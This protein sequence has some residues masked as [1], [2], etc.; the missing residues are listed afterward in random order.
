MFT[1]QQEKQEG[2]DEGVAEVE[3][4]AD[5]SFNFQLGEIVVDAVAEEVHRGRGAR[6]ERPPPPIV[7]LQRR[8]FINSIYTATSL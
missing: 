3:E 7:I 1:C 8:L 4:R 2:H 5:E 6:Q